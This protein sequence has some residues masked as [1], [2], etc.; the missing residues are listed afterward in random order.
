MTEW[1]ILAAIYFGFNI[2][3]LAN[4]VVEM[5]F[6]KRKGEPVFKDTNPSDGLQTFANYTIFLP[7]SLVLNL[8]TATIFKKDWKEAK[9]KSDEVKRKVYGHKKKVDE[10]ENRK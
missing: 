1:L 5:I 9:E 2:F 8:L 10:D 4:V 7:S 6:R 3:M